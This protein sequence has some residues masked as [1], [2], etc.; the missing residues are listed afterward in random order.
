VNLE[1]IYV[2]SEEFSFEELLAKKRGLYGLKLEAKSPVEN[3]FQ[4]L[5]KSPE[6]VFK[7]DRQ[8]SPDNVLKP[9]RRSPLQQKPIVRTPSP[10]PVKVDNDDGIVYMPI[11]GTS[12]SAVT[13]LRRGLVASETPQETSVPHNQ[14]KS[15]T[16]RYYRYLLAAIEVTAR[17]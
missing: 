1:Q 4:A 9:V 17:R 13:N 12:S 5:E 6:I 8:R 3:V 2:D 16:G 10:P 11:R 7:S 14:H 15:G